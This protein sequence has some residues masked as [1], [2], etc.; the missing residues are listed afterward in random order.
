M[1]LAAASHT[2]IAA[3]AGEPLLQPWR[4]VGVHSY[5]P[6]SLHAHVRVRNPARPQTAERARTSALSAELDAARK[7]QFALKKHVNVASQEARQVRREYDNLSDLA[8]EACERNAREVDAAN[9]KTRRM[10]EANRI[11][12]E[13]VARAEK[14]V[15]ASTQSLATEKAENDELRSAIKELGAQLHAAQAALSTEVG[16]A[17]PGCDAAINFGIW[18]DMTAGLET[19]KAWPCPSVL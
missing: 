15:A 13:R 7:Y 5:L 6:L 11:L 9:A 16:K 4:G 14:S 17:K 3:T 8:R 1:R 2:Q 19:I 18:S 10:S 12:E